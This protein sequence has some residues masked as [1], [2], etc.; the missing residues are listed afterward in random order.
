MSAFF[1]MDNKKFITVTCSSCGYTEMYK[2][3][4]SS[5]NKILDFFGN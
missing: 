2:G 3:E 4:V 1:N 5:L